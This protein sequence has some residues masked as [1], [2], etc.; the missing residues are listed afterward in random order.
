MENGEVKLSPEHF[1]F[2]QWDLTNKRST[3]VVYT[4][5]ELVQVLRDRRAKKERDHSS[6]LETIKRIKDEEI[7]NNRPPED[8]DF[9]DE[10]ENLEGILDEDKRL[11]SADTVDLKVVQK[12]ETKVSE[13]IRRRGKDIGGWNRFFEDPDIHGCIAFKDRSDFMASFLTEY[14]IDAW[15]DFFDEHY[16]PTIIE[17]LHSFPL[18]HLSLPGYNDNFSFKE[19]V[20]EQFSKDNRWRTSAILAGSLVGVSLLVRTLYSMWNSAGNSDIVSQSG[21]Y[22]TPVKVNRDYKN[23][24]QLVQATPQSGDPA[25]VEGM[26]MYHKIFE[27]NQYLLHEGDVRYGSILFICDRYAVMPSHFVHLW[28][29]RCKEDPNS[30]YGKTELTLTRC[31]PTH[32]DTK[33]WSIL[34]QEIIAGLVLNDELEQ[35][36]LCIIKFPKRF[37]VHLDIR[38]HFKA[39]SETSPVY[40]A[41]RRFHYDKE[42]K[43]DLRVITRDLST[44]RAVFHKQYVL[45]WLGSGDRTMNGGAY[46][47]NMTN[48]VGYCGDAV[49]EMNVSRQKG[50]IIGLHTAGNIP[51]MKSFC[52]PIY[53]EDFKCISYAVVDPLVEQSVSVQFGAN[54]DPLNHKFV[55]LGLTEK[56]T[57]ASKTSFQRSR[58]FGRVSE[59]ITAP[60]RI[61]PFYKEGVLVDPEIKALE[62][63]NKVQNVV[64]PIDVMNSLVASEIDWYKR[65]M[66]L[67]VQ[68]RVLTF[69][70]A[71][72]GIE[73]ETNIGSISRK[74]SPGYPY[75][76]DRREEASLSGLEMIMSMT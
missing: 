48:S 8:E 75:V 44:S 57:K 32:K 17:M 67:F 71:I 62:R 50:K 36:D 1:R 27:R 41:V 39:R 46:Y 63:Y 68:D 23:L 69:E 20:K 65:T 52:S 9:F 73:G 22:N 42:S 14:G 19:F 64:V 59:V 30:E 35:R 74:T 6:N 12:F 34:V 37:N 53:K 29:T 24:T 56:L 51:L 61:L 33:Q 70:E 5:Q 76:L 60:A 40:D 16:D 3:G 47:M 54:P 55:R 2:C 18:V 31:V 11:N 25:D 66:R 49:T 28:V 21:N 72:M 26:R 4:F 10:L 43:H 58:F 13:R 15:K 38:N 7:R 45:N